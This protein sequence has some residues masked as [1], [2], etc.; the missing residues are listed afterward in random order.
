MGGSLIYLMGPSGAGKDTLLEIAKVRFAGLWGIKFARR[1][2]TRPANA[3]GEDF[4]SISQP[5][6]DYLDAKGYFFFSWRSHGLSYGVDRQTGQFLKSGFMVVVNGSR[7]YLPRA[8]ELCPKLKPVLVTAEAGV[9]AAR[10]KNRGRESFDELTERLRQ[11]DYDCHRVKNIHI[12][13]N[14]EELE[15]AADKFCSFL[16]DEMSGNELT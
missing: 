5:A 3:G 1:Y 9:L 15:I 11:P 14:S 2:I 6:F 13:D 4:T 12:I 7:A 10:L 16:S 8:L